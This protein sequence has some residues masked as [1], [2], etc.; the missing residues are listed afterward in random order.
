MVIIYNYTIYGAL[1]L[2]ILYRQVA[3]K[4]FYTVQSCPG[5]NGGRPCIVNYIDILVFVLSNNKVSLL[6]WQKSKLVL[7]LVKLSVLSAF[8]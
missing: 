5:W 4:N 7:K 8:I 6:V 1:L 3:V 2:K